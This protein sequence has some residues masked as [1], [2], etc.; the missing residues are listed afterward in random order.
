MNLLEEKWLPV[1]RSTGQIDW[2]APHQISEPDIVAFAANRPDFNGALAQMMI[3][4]L[5]TTTPV[6]DEDDWEVLLDKQPSAEELQQWFAPVDEA[7][8]LDGDGARFMQ[9]IGLD[10][11]ATDPSKL[12]EISLLFIDAPGVS[13]QKDNKDLFVKRSLING[14]CPHCTA[15]ALFTLQTN[16]PEGG[17]GNYTSLRGGGPL[18]TLVVATPSRSLWQDLWLNVKPQKAFL[19]QGGDV[20]KTA[21][22]FTFPWLAETIK[23][24]PAGG[25][26]QPLQVHP[27]HVFWAMP[28]RIR[29]DFD[30]VQSG[31][32]DV[33]KR[34]STQLQHR[35]VAKPKGLNYKGVWRHPFSPY[36]EAKEGWR[37]VHPQPN[38]FSYKNWLAWV[39][40]VQQ[41]GE[42]VQ[43]ASIV[44][45]FLQE[46]K[47]YQAS[48][49]FRLWVFG[50]D[51]DSMTARCWYETT[52]PLY[53]LADAKL[54][55]QTQFQNLIT[56]RVEAS[57]Q[58]AL[59]L[60]QAVKEA[61][62]PKRNGKVEMRGDLSF[63][64]KAFWDNTE[65]D[66]YQQLYDLMQQARSESGIDM[67]D[68][69]FI[70]T[71]GE[72]WLKV[73]TDSATK[74][75]DVDIVGAGS[76][77]QQD[78]RRIAEAYNHLRW[79][80]NGDAIKAILRLPVSEKKS[81]KSKSTVAA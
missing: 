26:T 2:I 24:Q 36:Y 64:D 62:F 40:G 4:L 3:G 76:I 58:A 14:I 17:A 19:R 9:D 38:G 8:V 54:I 46:R 59:Y 22:H 73:L 34:E 23:I 28:R 30:D 5:Q 48:G 13:T 81:K 1:R 16:A 55:T 69:N 49:Q 67:D 61:W 68:A 25:E 52:L 53:V 15:T 45:Y 7:F 35:Y 32:C 65:A 74:L 60:S 31:R 42:G 18:T 27:H 43:A 47:K 10:I 33:C 21:K 12:K 39:L 20:Q 11:R 71:L 66:F 70:I 50:Y 37:P 75:F 41:E 57:E 72:A 80:L 51:M 6:S 63:V 29:V 56:S 78:P 79:N 44:D 77:S